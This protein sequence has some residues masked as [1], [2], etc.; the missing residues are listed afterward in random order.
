MTERRRPRWLS[1]VVKA[2]L[3][4]A[5]IALVLGL[6]DVQAVW[7]RITQ[8]E[9]S[10]LL[11]AVGL[12][13]TQ[14]LLAGTRW[15]IIGKGTGG[16]VAPW[17]AMRATFA[18]MFCNQLLPTSIGGD[19]V[20]VGI[21][22]GQ[23]LTVG[24]AART[25]VLDRTA[26]LLSLLTLMGLT[27]FVLSDQLPKTW[28]VDLIRLIPAIA[29]GV[30][31]VALIM[32]NRIAAALE[33]R[34][35]LPWFAQLFR[36]SSALLRHGARTVI[37]LALSYAIHAASAASV[38]ILAQGSGVEIGYAQ[39]LGFLPIVILVQMLPISIAGWGV[40]EGT[41]VTLFALLGIGSAPAVAVS[42]LWGGCIALGALAS[43]LIWAATRPKGKRLASGEPPQAP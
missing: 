1:V 17:T 31:L 18:A 28:P 12:C 5:M 10:T 4:A 39:V 43:G 23:G 35:V 8:I 41:I 7:A 14:I 9:I 34:G 2:G 19:V 20:R 6:A 24:R 29:I 42:I 22:A 36:D 11:L 3:S 30:V 25:V 37:I 26:G 38:W 27:G 16:F 15:T 13:F 21:I 32:G 40:R 33:A